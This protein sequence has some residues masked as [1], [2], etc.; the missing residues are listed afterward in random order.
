MSAELADYHFHLPITEEEDLR[1]FLEKAFGVRIPDVA[2]CDG[3]VSPWSAF[4]ESFFARTPV[5]VWVGARG[6]G[7]KTFMM[8]TLSLAEAILLGASVNVLGGSGEQSARLLET[9]DVLWS[10]E[11]APRELLRSAPAAHRT[12][13]KGGAKILAL[14]ASQHSARGGHPHRLRMDEVDDM[15][16]AIL[17]AALGQVGPAPGVASQITLGGTYHNPDGT[18][19]HVLNELA[20]EKGWPVRRWCW[21]ESL[22]T[23]PEATRPATATEP[24]RPVQ[25]NGWL[26]DEKLERT[27]LAVPD[28]MWAV[29]YDLQ[30]P[31]AEGRIFSEEQLKSLFR[32]DLGVVRNDIH[33][34]WRADAL[35]SLVVY[36]HGQDLAEDR[37]HSVR[38]GIK[39]DE[40]PWRIVDYE[41]SRGVAYEVTA[42][43]FR[44]ALAV[45]PGPSRFDKTG[46][47]TMFDR[48][49]LYDEKG[50]LVGPIANCEGLKTTPGLGRGPG[51][52]SRALLLGQYATAVSHGKIVGPWI[53]TLEEEHRY[54]NQ[55]QL[56]GKGHPPDGIVGCALAYDAALS[57]A[58]LG[59]PVLN[60]EKTPSYWRSFDG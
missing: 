42:M 60:L 23:P 22:Y 49:L 55:D 8:G 38:V 3:H 52:I 11:S 14:K 6:L 58:G 30:E 25:I 5:T 39:V 48:L 40:T 57:I 26:S 4:C 18:M 17:L 29:E 35:P 41:R 51:T 9:H 44:S 21:R 24:A 54:A 59:A 50:D 13:L 43:R 19:R 31:S 20:R 46:P 28:S 36:A 7:G 27:R 47:G 15:E 53:E 1:I 45:L 12:R 2:V 56:F 16:L 10:H 37:H 33:E 34:A 32:K